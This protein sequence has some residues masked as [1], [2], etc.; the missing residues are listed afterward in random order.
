MD[1]K[2]RI[3]EILKERNT[4]PLF[5]DQLMEILDITREERGVLLDILN[6]M[7]EDG[8]LVMTRK[9]KYALPQTLGLLV[10]RLQ[11]NARGFAFLFLM[12]K[13]KKMYLFRLRI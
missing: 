2:T 1:I 8:Q 12:Q 5:P 4:P 3:L 6:D 7:V 9:K 13:M 11:G 10:G